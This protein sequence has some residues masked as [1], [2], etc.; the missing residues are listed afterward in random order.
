MY[1]CSTLTATEGC[2]DAFILIE[3]DGWICTNLLL[4]FIIRNA[5]I[6]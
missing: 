1:I 5:L 4:L 6:L 3:M 2:L